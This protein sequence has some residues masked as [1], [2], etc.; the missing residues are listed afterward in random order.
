M[1]ASGET[2]AYFALRPKTR[3]KHGNS[4]MIHRIRIFIQF[5]YF[6]YCLWQDHLIDHVNNA[7]T[8]FNV[9][10]DDLGAHFVGIAASFLVGHSV[11]AHGPCLLAIGHLCFFGT[12]Q[13][14]GSNHSIRDNM[15]RQD[16]SDIVFEWRGTVEGVI[17]WGKDSP[18]SA[19][20]IIG[21]TVFCNQCAKSGEAFVIASKID[22][23]KQFEPNE[24]NE[25]FM[26]NIL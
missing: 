18:Q 7:V 8:S 24:L 22:C 21:K 6:L 26:G 13:V 15:F 25:K 10:F 9:G 11:L 5:I 12:Y 23:L 4:K 17:R 1:F 14:L 19:T 2:S 3:M 20:Q 16:E